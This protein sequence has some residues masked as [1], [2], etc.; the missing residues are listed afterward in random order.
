[1]DDE[2]LESM[3]WDDIDTSS[4]ERQLQ[5]ESITDSDLQPQVS[6]ARLL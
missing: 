5:H 1:M 2:E 4:I 3:L 6:I